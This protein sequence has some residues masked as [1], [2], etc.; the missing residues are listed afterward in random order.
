M[1]TKPVFIARNTFPFVEMWT[2]EY[3][4]NAGFAVSQQ[5]KNIAAIHEAFRAKFPGKEVL[6]ASSKSD[7][8]EGRALSAF[9]LG[10]EVPSLGKSVPVECA[11]QAGKVFEAGGPYTDLLEAKPRD[12]KRDARLSSSGA[13]KAFSFEGELFPLVPMNAFYDWLYIRGLLA[14]DRLREVVR[15]YDAFTDVSFNPQKSKSC[16]ARTCAVA[17]A[18]LMAGGLEGVLDLD[19]R[20]SFERYLECA[21]F[22]R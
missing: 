22:S 3:A 13:L 19:G 17:S 2:A 20:A 6:E 12:A 10:V 14:N 16:Q 18:L 11:Y 9:A 7:L 8:E 15:S 21:G 5:R 1:A 4:F